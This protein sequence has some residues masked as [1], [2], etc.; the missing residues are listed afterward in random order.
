MDLIVLM[1]VVSAALAAGVLAAYGVCLAMF[2]TFRMH[3]TQVALEKGASSSSPV[4]AGAA[5][6]IGS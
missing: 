4:T 6:A 5:P 3:V 2:A 1:C